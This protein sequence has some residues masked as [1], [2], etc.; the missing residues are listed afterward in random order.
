M[1]F[2]SRNNICLPYNSLIFEKIKLNFY[3][4]KV[5][6]SS[7][8]DHKATVYLYENKIFRKIIKNL[9]IN[10]ENFLTSSFY[11]KNKD[12]IIKT[13]IVSLENEK[14]FKFIKD[15][16]ILW[17]E[18]E[19]IDNIVYPYEYT[20]DQLKDSAIFFLDLYI[21]SIK[22]LYE[23][24]DASAYNIQFKNNKPIFID[25]GSFNKL[26]KKSH[27][28][29]HK[30][31]CENY[32]APLLI[33]SQ[34]DL[35]FNDLYRSNLNG[36]ELKYASKILPIKSWFKFNILMNIHLHT[37]LNHKISSSSHFKQNKKTN[38]FDVKKKILIAE[39]LKKT[40]SNLNCKNTTYWS[41]YSKLNSYTNET[42]KNKIDAVSHFIQN[43]KI[44]KL[45]DIGCNNGFFSEVSF[46]NGAQEIIGIDSDLDSLN[47]SYL[48]FKNL[49]KNYFPIYQNFVNPSA[50]IGWQNKERKSFI[51]RYRYKFDGV[52]C[53]AFIHH[54]CIGNNIPIEQ[55][56]E[57]LGNFSKNFLLEFIST[58]D[59]MVENL[60][61]NKKTIIK[62]YDLEILKNIIK[63][64]YTIISEHKISN[65]R[66]MLH[67]KK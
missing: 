27:I 3:M 62:N 65:T 10:F 42:K 64:E 35:N 54:I 51:D 12:K 57:Y 1:D 67:F 7:F 53:L 58:E 56:I 61:L 4:L 21:D 2:A 11:Y 29:W 44:K 59:K 30:Q 60:L 38:I 26:D 6:N 45:L 32:L 36:I 18:H 20:F 19:K 8:R 25:I 48:K 63:K 66:T 23:I 46:N 13:K 43:Q 41:N 33:K 34:S 9:N 40:I 17:L 39:S 28:L 24:I 50:N 49:G 31:F 15:D 55:F 52:I 16:N 22:N 47:Q 5:E 14:K 37:Y